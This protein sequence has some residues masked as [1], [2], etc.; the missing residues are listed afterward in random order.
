MFWSI[1]MSLFSPILKSTS[2][3]FLPVCFCLL[4]R[5]FFFCFSK[6][7]CIL[8][9][10]Q[11]FCI[12]YTSLHTF[13]RDC[14]LSSIYDDWLDMALSVAQ[15]TSRRAREVWRLVW[16]DHLYT[17]L[18]ALQTGPCYSLW[19]HSSLRSPR[20]KQKGR[21]NA[22]AV[23]I[24]RNAPVNYVCMFVKYFVLCA[25]IVVVVK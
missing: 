23:E 25:S 15:V 14:L 19:L 11:H 6:F 2:S 18:L 21:A 24:K 5:V 16:R 1:N 9:F 22:L 8:C 10:C 20:S 17:R 3:L 13:E 7:Y 4:S 12:F